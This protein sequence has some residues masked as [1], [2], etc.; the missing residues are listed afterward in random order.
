MFNVLKLNEISSKVNDIL[1]KDKYAI[2]DECQNPDAII[3]R[4]FD[5]HTYELPTSVV[6]IAR[7]GAGVNNIPLDQMTAK[8]VCVFNTPGANANAVKELV[9]CAL[10]L[11]SRKIVDGINW[12][13]TLAGSDNVEKAVEKGKKEFIG[14]EVYGK[15][16]GVIG[17]GA[18]GRMVA[19]TAIELGMNVIGYD[20]FLNVNGAMALDKH[21]KYVSDIKRVYTQSD[22]ITLHVPATPDTKNSINE[23]TIALMK[24][25]VVLINCA[26]ADLV[27]NADVIKAVKAGKIGRYITD[28]PSADLLGVDNIIAIPHL[29]ASTP[30]AEENCAIMAANQL[31]DYMEN[32]NVTNSVNYPC[33]VAPRTTANR[34][35][36]LHA[37]VANMIAK[38]TNYIASQ[39]INISNLVSASRGEIGYM[40]IDID[41]K[42]PEATLKAM[43]NE[44]GFICVRDYK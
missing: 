11:G 39:N 6:A 20:P 28:L 5:M 8:S 37:N 16:L 1:K 31:K 41:K 7:A 27:C 30:E 10:M 4:S 14:R 29:G 24:Q 32:G 42:L 22:Y 33:A 18:I 21:I 9:I 36:I 25:D 38:A 15:T 3:L 34:I 12:T 2:T 43:R 23:K 13:K 35:T 19:N 40:L 17:L 44:E 26:R